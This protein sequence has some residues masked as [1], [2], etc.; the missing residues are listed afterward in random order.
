MRVRRAWRIVRTGI[1]FATFGLLA[2][3]IGW[4]WLPLQRLR[5]ESGEL[6]AQRAIRGA[7]RFFVWWSARLGLIRV[8]WQGAGRLHAAAGMLVVSNHPTLI[9][10][11]LIGAELPQMDLIAGRSWAENPYMRGAVRAAG[12][13][14]NDQGGAL[15]EEAAQRLRRGRTLLVFPEGTRSPASGLGPFRRGAAHISLAS[16]CE[17]LPVC[18]SCRPRTLMKGQRWYEVPERQVEYSIEVGEPI[19]PK[20]VL[21]A[22]QPRARAA[23]RLN[24]ELRELYLARLSPRGRNE[25]RWAIP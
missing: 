9:D 7:F 1:A 10:V 3:G 6:A 18:I 23:R 4:V 15:I 21:D 25:D 13:L 5:G 19:S 12:Y 24:A 16:G 8:R 2:L 22:G 14:C 11:V 20:P 17:I